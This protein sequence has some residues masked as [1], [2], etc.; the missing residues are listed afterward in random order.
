MPSNFESYDEIPTNVEAY[1]LTVADVDDIT[2]LSL[3]D[4]NDYLNQFEEWEN[5]QVYFNSLGE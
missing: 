4:I 5:M 2:E 3:D 1:M